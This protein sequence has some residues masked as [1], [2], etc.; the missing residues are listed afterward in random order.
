MTGTAAGTRPARP[1]AQAGN[2][3]LALSLPALDDRV[4]R[5]PK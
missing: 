5:H 3:Q 1:G 4:I 2:A